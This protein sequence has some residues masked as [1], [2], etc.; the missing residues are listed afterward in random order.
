MDQLIVTL[1]GKDHYIGQGEHTV[2]YLPVPIGSTR[3]E[4]AKQCKTCFGLVDEPAV[5]PADEPSP[6]P[7]VETASEPEPKA[8]KKA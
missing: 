8:K 7:V 4:G 1:D 2:C 6:E 5:W 3:E